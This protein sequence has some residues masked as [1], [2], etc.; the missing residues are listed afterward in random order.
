MRGARMLHAALGGETRPRRSAYGRGRGRGWRR[1]QTGGAGDQSVCAADGGRA[2]E[3]PVLRAWLVCSATVCFCAVVCPASTHVLFASS[4]AASARYVAPKNVSPAAAML[5]LR[6]FSA[7]QLTCSRCP[8]GRY[9]L[10]GKAPLAEACLYCGAGR[11][12]AAGSMEAACGGACAAG[13][14]GYGGSADASCSGACAAGHWGGPGSV[15][16]TCAGKCPA[17][18]FSGPGWAT[19][20]C[21]GGARRVLSLGACAATLAHFNSPSHASAPAAPI[22]AVRAVL[23]LAGSCRLPARSLFSLLSPG[24]AGRARLRSGRSSTLTR[25]RRR[26]SV[27]P[28]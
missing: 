19:C 1:Q 17:G 10:G 7:A 2:V 23:L 26:C 16:A 8:A 9:S 3:A 5:P 13:R 18:K 21:V 4:L 11:W 15:M 28:R 22:Y 12:G 25:L 20:K 14:F 24:D 27:R 6:A